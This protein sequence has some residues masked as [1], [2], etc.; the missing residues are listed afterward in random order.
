MHEEILSFDPDPAARLD[1]AYFARATACTMLIE[2]AEALWKPIAD[3]DEWWVFRDK[4]AEIEEMGEAYPGLLIGLTAED[5]PIVVGR[6]EQAVAQ[7]VV[8]RIGDRRSRGGPRREP[9][10]GLSP[11]ACRAP[12]SGRAPATPAPCDAAC[13]RGCPDRERR[14]R[15]R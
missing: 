12:T 7:F 10:E 1:H 9:H 4:L 15:P 6:A 8:R 14:A 13:R 5:M 2:E 11:R 3:R